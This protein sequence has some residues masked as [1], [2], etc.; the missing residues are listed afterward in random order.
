MY[1]FK[2]L[3]KPVPIVLK[4]W[5]MRNPINTFQDDIL[6][7]TLIF[8]NISN[9]LPLHLIRH[10]MNFRV[11]IQSDIKPC[12]VH[13]LTDFDDPSISLKRGKI[14]NYFFPQNIFY[15]NTQKHVNVTNKNNINIYVCVY[16]YV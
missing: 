11:L 5:S 2:D 9:Y 10:Q 15:L 1:V 7:K 4:I 16:I 8:K 13:V 6:P 12:R 3:K 14:P